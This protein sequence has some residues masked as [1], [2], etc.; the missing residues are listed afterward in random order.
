ML[1]HYERRNFLITGS[2]ILSSSAVSTTRRSALGLDFEISGSNSDPSTV[3]SILLEFDTLKLIPQSLDESQQMNIKVKIETEESSTQK[4]ETEDFS[5]QN[6]EIV[7][8]NDINSR[9]STD[10][11][12]LV[13]EGLN[14]EKSYIRSSVDLIVNHSDISPQTYSQSFTISGKYSNVID[15]FEDGDVSDWSNFSGNQISAVKTT[16]NGG[17]AYNGTY[18]AEEKLTSGNNSTSYKDLS[19]NIS[20]ENISV[21]IRLE[22]AESGNAERGFFDFYNSGSRVFNVAMDTRNGDI[23]INWQGYRDTISTGVNISQNTWFNIDFVDIDWTNNE[24]GSVVI[25]GTNVLTNISFVS[26]SSYINKIRH[27]CAGTGN[28]VSYSDMWSSS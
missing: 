25:D 11:S 14:T 18:C 24:I 27:S 21:A 6:G 7:T 3:D 4:I 9:Q 12:S 1:K 10:I 17:S 2:A 28:A 8:L 16:S 13:V 19:S 22:N 23:D 26:N 15:D 20:P 5:F